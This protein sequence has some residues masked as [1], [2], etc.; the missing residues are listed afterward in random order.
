M[1]SSI[2]AERILLSKRVGYRGQ[3]LDA[4]R[5]ETA[6]W[7]RDAFNQLAI[8]LFTKA[9][10]ATEE[11]AKQTATRVRKCGEGFERII[12]HETYFEFEISRLVRDLL[13]L[14]HRGCTALDPDR[15]RGR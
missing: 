4:E 8:L 14:K 5:K 11:R 10:P 6:K 7:G 12:L 9:T 2:L 13:K 15:C 3:V 1:P